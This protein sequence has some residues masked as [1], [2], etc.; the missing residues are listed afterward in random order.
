MKTFKNTS[1]LKRDYECTNVV[2]CQGNAPPEGT[3]EEC[4]ESILIGIK[5]LWIIAGVRF[6]GH[7]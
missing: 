1:F 7:M 5:P 3:W 2:A 6:F 4:D